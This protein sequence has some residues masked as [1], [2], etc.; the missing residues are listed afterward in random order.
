MIPAVPMSSSLRLV[1]PH[2]PSPPSTILNPER[3]P[4]SPQAGLCEE[5]PG[6]KPPKQHL[7]PLYCC[8]CTHSA[9]FFYCLT[10]VCA[11]L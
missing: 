8:L 4:T 10:T 5:K 2:R 7:L 11:P 6:G 1:S 3:H 9:R